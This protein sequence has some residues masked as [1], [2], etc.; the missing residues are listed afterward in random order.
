[1][2][3]G[4]AVVTVAA[5]AL[6]AAPPAVVALR[7]P[8]ERKAAGEREYRSCLRMVGIPLNVSLDM[9]WEHKKKSGWRHVPR[10]A[11]QARA[12]RRRLEALG[13]ML[14][15]PPDGRAKE[16]AAPTH[17]P[18]HESDGQNVL[19]IDGHVTWYPLKKK[20]GEPVTPEPPPGGHEPSGQGD[21]YI[22]GHV[23]W[24]RLNLGPKKKSGENTPW[25]V[26][27]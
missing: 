17:S 24:H 15:P 26:L 8:P 16:E 18:G 25:F 11:D 13:V 27:E 14:M 9:M 19:Y 22:D 4:F 10:P 3:R 6:A 5:V 23:D 1:M 21:L 7:P 20:S 2:A 12:Y